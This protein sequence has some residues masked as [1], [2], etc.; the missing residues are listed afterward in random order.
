MSIARCYIDAIFQVCLRTLN[1]DTVRPICGDERL[2]EDEEEFGYR[3]KNR[4]FG[5]L[6]GIRYC[7]KNNLLFGKFGYKFI[8]NVHFRKIKTDDKNKAEKL[9]A[10]A[11]NLYFDVI[12]A[13]ITILPLHQCT[14]VYYYK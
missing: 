7:G 4:R 11:C 2:T 5:S 1:C 14:S 3:F 6:L 12:D 13:T 10:D 8:W 9:L